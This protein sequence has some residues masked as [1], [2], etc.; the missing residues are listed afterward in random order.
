[1]VRIF[2]IP[3]FFVT[4]GDTA[5]SFGQ[6]L[7]GHF[8]WLGSIQESTPAWFKAMVSPEDKYE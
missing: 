5:L 3:R 6:K 1:V 8:D 4:R 7:K 2:E